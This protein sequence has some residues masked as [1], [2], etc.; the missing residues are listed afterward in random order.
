M[1][2]IKVFQHRTKYKPW[3]TEDTKDMI[4]KR[5]NE[6]EEA[7]LTGDPTK[8][9]NYRE[10]RNKVNGAVGKDR[11]THYKEMYERHLNEKDTG[12]IFKTAKLQS[13]WKSNATPV[14]FKVAGKHITNP[15]DMANEQMKAFRTKTEKLIQER[16]RKQLI[17]FP[18]RERH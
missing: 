15:K 3:L 2:P 16:Q 5:D 8:W 7:R 6:R 1:C 10:T 17:Q 14:S 9:K 4:T 11:K 18:S 12:G 13:G